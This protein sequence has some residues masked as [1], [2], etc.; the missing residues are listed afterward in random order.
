MGGMAVVDV[1]TFR[2]TGDEQSFR[3]ADARMQT[4]FTYLQPGCLRRTTARSDNGEWVVIT[5][6]ATAGDADAATAA[7]RTDQIAAAFQ[8]CVDDESVRNRRYT[9]LE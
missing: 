4:E 5:L 7:A 2:L 8:A 1:T 9:L 3:A 6:W